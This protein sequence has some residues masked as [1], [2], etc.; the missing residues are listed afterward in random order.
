M[1]E[2]QTKVFSPK[3]FLKSRRPERFTDSILREHGKLD[4][5]VLEHQLSTLNRRSLELE[6]EN[7]SKSLCE[8]VICPNLLEQTGPVAG[9]D[10]KTDTQTFP[11]S[12]QIKTLRWYIGVNDNA[13]QD[14]WA[15]AV[16]TR[17]DWK[18]KCKEDVR[19]IVETD[20]NYKKVFCITSQYCKSNQRSEVEDTI[21]KETGVD[22]RIYDASWILDQV[23]T[24]GYEE[25]AVDA[26]SIEI[27]W[28]REKIDGPNDYRKKQELEKLQKNIREK[29]DPAVV[30][31]H[32]VSWFIEE[33][34]LCKELEYPTIES[35]GLFDRAV[36]IASQFGNKFHQFDAHYQYAW[37]AFWWYEN[38]S[39]FEEQLQKSFE[40][41]QEIDQS[42][43]WGNLISLLGLYIRSPNQT[44]A[45]DTELDINNIVS[46]TEKTLKN[47]TEDTTRPSNALLAKAYNALLGLHQLNSP[48]QAS[49]IFLTFENVIEDSKNLVGFPF[50]DIYE[51]ISCMDFAFS[52]NGSYERL[53]DKLTQLAIERG[54]DV[55]GSLLLLSRGANRL[56]S[57]KPYQAIK[58]IGRSLVGLYK[59]ESKKDI[60]AGLN[61]LSSAYQRIGLFWASRSALL[62]AGSL[63]TDE[64]WKSG[65]LLAAQVHS[66]TRLAESELLLGRINYALSW[67]DLAKTVNL[68]L[69]ES[70]ISE[71]AYFTFDGYL[72]HC[73][74]NSKLSSLR[75]LEKIPD[76]LK[77][78]EL[79]FSQQATLYALGHEDL[80]DEEFE[81]GADGDLVK[82]MTM[83]RD[84]DF[85]V[86]TTKLHTYQERHS[87]LQS[88]IM[89]CT[90]KISF[91][92]KDIATRLS[93]GILS[94]LEAFF[95]TCI[96]DD[97]IAIESK[98][99][100]EI[101]LD[102][103]DFEISHQFMKEEA[104]LSASILLSSFTHEK[105]INEEALIADWLFKFVVEIFSQLFTAKDF[106]KAIHT[107]L[108][109]DRALDRS[110]SLGKCLYGLT[111]IFGY[112]AHEYIHS[113]L[114]DEEL[115]RY[116]LKRELSWDS[117]HPKVIEQH[118][119]IKD[120]EVDV[121]DDTTSIFEPE[122]LSHRD[123]QVQSLIKSR[124]WDQT[125]WKGLAFALYPNMQPVMS[126]VFESKDVAKKILSDLK[127]EVG[128]TNKNERLQISIIRK[129]N[130][131]QLTYYRVVI[132][133]KP[134]SSGSSKVINTFSRLNTMEPENDINLTRFLDLYAQK[135]SF[136]LS[137]T[138]IENGYPAM[139]DDDLLIQLNT[140]SVVDAWQVGPNTFEQVGIREDD[141][142]FLPPDIEKPPFLELKEKLFRT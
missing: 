19:K 124:L 23:F 70:A 113:L 118:I 104:F 22:V 86:P 60:Y 67:W 35:Q 4:R 122:Q 3:E 120:S 24:H 2:Q 46:V 53:L 65:E 111:N 131:N 117:E 33:A 125:V 98:L 110:I 13:H 32:Q 87:S 106:E 51:L 50:Q 45:N 28:S 140:L 73:I 5:A 94:V 59:E 8:K 89:G 126:L 82:F 6:F 75:N 20:R 108:R 12:E 62:L 88:Y 57:G 116:P 11:V 97:I 30:K 9:G 76:R 105:L 85:G 17:Q 133:E 93:E 132:S 142:P 41:A 109:E 66:Y 135:R 91:P 71:N 121:A 137:C 55:K 61:V 90:I 95:S 49:Q 27:D 40:K 44:T 102:D 115:T 38:H 83:I 127:S 56:N 69:E 92:Q 26:L 7:F 43:V 1:T 101:S 136:L 18:Q 114:G 21:S 42:G 54:G 139:P 16:S 141:D 81:Q 37:A 14:R 47:F 72:N 77:Q 39:L 31:K 80:I 107:M 96:V 36:K 34:L 79:M 100:I 48:E 58:L 15:F 128:F 64:Y 84:Y 29:V 63:I 119:S 99:E 134:I 138:Y 52:E 129:I 10:G 25:L 74:L 123:T 112:N 78:L 130:K 68:N 103:D